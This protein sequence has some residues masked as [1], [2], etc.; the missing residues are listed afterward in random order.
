[1]TWPVMPRWMAQVEP[2]D[3]RS[4]S[5]LP[6]RSTS[7]MLWPLIPAL[8]A[9]G[10]GRTSLASPTLS[11]VGVR[12]RRPGAKVRRTHSTSGSSGMR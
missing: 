6:W 11:E 5:S 7:D 10:V 12:P 8:R 9:W 1:M 4:I 2:P 3:I